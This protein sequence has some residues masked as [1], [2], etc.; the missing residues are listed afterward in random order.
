MSTSCYL[1]LPDTKHQGPGICKGKASVYGISGFFGIQEPTWQGSARALSDYLYLP[2]MKHQGKKFADHDVQILSD[3]L[4]RPDMKHQGPRI[5]KGKASVHGIKGTASVYGISGF[6][7]SG[8][9]F[10]DHDVESDCLGLLRGNTLLYSYHAY[11]N[12]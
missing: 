10:A 12:C 2:D 8:K 11:L 4:C 7:Q 1:Y 3:Y 6:R 5:C 9:K